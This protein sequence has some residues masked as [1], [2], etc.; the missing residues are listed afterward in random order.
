MHHQARAG[1]GDGVFELK[2]ECVEQVKDESRKKFAGVR[3]HGCEAGLA[4][5]AQAGSRSPLS[6]RCGPRSYTAHGARSA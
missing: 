2:S 1:D 3:S 6:I 4:N 5:L